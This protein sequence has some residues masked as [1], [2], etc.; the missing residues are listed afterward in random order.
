[1]AEEFRFPNDD[2]FGSSSNVSLDP[3]LEDSNKLLIPA[4]VSD[5]S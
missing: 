4:N 3:P 2:D 1:M 5:T